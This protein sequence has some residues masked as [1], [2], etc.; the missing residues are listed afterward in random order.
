[1]EWF[2]LWVLVSPPFKILLKGSKLRNSLYYLC[3]L[4]QS[5]KWSRVGNL[6]LLSLSTSQPLTLM[7]TWRKTNSLMWTMKPGGAQFWFFWLFGTGV[8]SRLLS[9]LFDMTVAMIIDSLIKYRVFILTVIP[10]KVPTSQTILWCEKWSQGGGGG[11]EGE[12]KTCF[13]YS[14]VS[15]LL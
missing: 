7:T 8:S 11:R 2:K 10:I 12:R 4:F 3:L 14:G 6:Q 1:M 13:P 15:V 9:F 5:R